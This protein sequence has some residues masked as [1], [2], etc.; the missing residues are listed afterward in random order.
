MKF[1]FETE[2]GDLVPI[3]V[4]TYSI[5]LAAQNGIQMCE[6]IIHNPDSMPEERTLAT[7]SKKAF[8]MILDWRQRHGDTID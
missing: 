4:V 6:A 5:L 3:S 7:S 8:G 2:P 1:S